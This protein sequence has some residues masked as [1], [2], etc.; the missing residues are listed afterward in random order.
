METK[1]DKLKTMKEDNSLSIEE[2]EEIAGGTSL[3][4]ADDS[5]FLNVLLRG[6]PAQPERFGEYKFEMAGWDDYMKMQR[7]ISLAWKACG[8]ELRQQGKGQ[9][10]NLYYHNGKLVTQEVAREIAMDAMGKHLCYDDW[11]W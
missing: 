2:M 8:I 7:S 5:R 10:V 9:E 6:H 4:C 11:H 3:E 1:L